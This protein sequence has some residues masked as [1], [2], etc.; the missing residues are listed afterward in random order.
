MGP[1]RTAIKIGLVNMKCI[2]LVV[3]AYINSYGAVDRQGAR[4]E[5]AH[6]VDTILE[7]TPSLQYVY[8]CK[9]SSVPAV[10][11]HKHG[12]IQG[13]EGTFVQDDPKTG[14]VTLSRLSENSFRSR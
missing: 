6:G 14:E 8:R 4:M 5:R 10:V 13:F 11:C 9:A 12:S 3:G 2:M 1:G 7:I